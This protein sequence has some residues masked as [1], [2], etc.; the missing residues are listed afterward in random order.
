MLL[1]SKFLL[2]VSIPFHTI[3]ECCFIAANSK[4]RTSQ[5]GKTYN[6]NLITY[7]NICQD[8]IRLQGHSEKYN[9]EIEVCDKKGRILEFKFN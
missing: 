3:H 5:V 8:L 6:L 2:Q 9:L 7:N 1:S 4:D